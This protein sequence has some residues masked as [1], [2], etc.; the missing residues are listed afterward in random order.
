V[1]P[2]V[3][4]GYAR[5]GSTW[6]QQVVF[7]QMDGVANA[8]QNALWTDMSW[9]LAVREDEA[10]YHETLRTFV[11]EFTERNAGSTCVFSQEMIADY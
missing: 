9:K 5:T 8:S 2:V 6:L 7:S 10:Y 11:N 4:I 1:L 3:H